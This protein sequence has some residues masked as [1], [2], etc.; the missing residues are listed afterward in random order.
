LHFAPADATLN[1]AGKETTMK[2]KAISIT[3][4][5][6]SLAT[7]AAL[8]ASF[9]EQMQAG[10]MT[11]TQVDRESG[12]FFC[13]EHKRW[14]RVPKADLALIG[15]GDIIGVEAHEGKIRVLRTAAEEMSSPE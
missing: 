13:A 8:A 2:S 11:I 15:V 3:V 4:V 5:A 12:Q 10:R 9:T 6:L 1:L 7:S 14:T